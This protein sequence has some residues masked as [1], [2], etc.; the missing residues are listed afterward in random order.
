MTNINNIVPKYAGLDV[1]TGR[2]A[3]LIFDPEGTSDPY[4][5]KCLRVFIDTLINHKQIICPLSSR[6]FADN[7]EDS[8][9]PNIIVEAKK[10][11]L[12]L[13]KTDVSADEIRL[14]IDILS[15]EYIR[16]S[17][18]AKEHS[19]ELNS[20][21][22][23]YQNPD[24]AKLRSKLVPKYLVHEFWSMKEKDDLHRETRIPES[25]LEFAF[26]FFVRGIKY[27]QMLGENT[28]FFP[29]PARERAFGFAP[30]EFQ[31]QNQWS[32]GEYF[33]HLLGENENKRDIIWL[34]DKIS[35][36]HLLTQKYNASWYNIKQHPIS[37]QL[38]LLSTIASEADMPA[39][40]KDKAHK[41]LKASLGIGTILT[42]GIPLVSVVLGF[43]TVLVELW[44]K[45]IPGKF[46]KIPIF[47][48]YLKWPGISGS[49]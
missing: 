8:F 3:D 49:K 2:C 44:N 31:G 16:F 40:I 48:G 7:L 30:I 23:Y 42:A 28:P 14:P 11:N 33:I 38:D 46:G 4:S 21:L 10:Q 26:D 24:H 36:I 19:L 25:E 43:S 6:I 45:D 20:W 29:H 9:F 27:H 13:F 39:K 41:A 34:V 35:S 22:E 17:S 32:W 37:S 12:I 5:S 15:K 47:K 1:T 18:W